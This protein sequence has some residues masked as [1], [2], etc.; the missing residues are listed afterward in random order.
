MRHSILLVCLGLILASP[1]ASL[2]EDG[3][4]EV[5]YDDRGLIAIQARLRITTTIVLPEDELIVDYICGDK[6]YWIVNGA[7]NIAHIKPAKAGGMTN[8]NLVTTSGRIYSFRLQEGSE[9][10]DF[11][12]L[13][14]SPGGATGASKRYYTSEE[15]AALRVQLA[16][17]QAA[18]AAA[19]QGAL[20]AIEAQ[21]ADYPTRLRFDYVFERNKRPF[22]VVAIWH[23]GAKTYIRSVARE[24]PALYEEKD[25]EPSMVQYQ[26]QDG[27]TYVIHKLL[28]RGYLMLGKEKL[29][30]R[31]ANAQ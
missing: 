4:R 30:F 23:D 20:E 6:D 29:H 14:T 17:A 21:R 8:L 10:P 22:S 28:E 13:V 31:L 2:A 3:I 25:G 12:V 27:G 5:Q 9:I 24:L 11:K 26:V 1:T 16:E 19:K 18:V 7:R 15:V